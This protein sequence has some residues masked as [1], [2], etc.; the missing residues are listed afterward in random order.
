MKLTDAKLLERWEEADDEHARV[1][2]WKRETRS[3]NE[4][5]RLRNR[6]WEIRKKTNRYRQEAGRRVF[7]D[8][9]PDMRKY[10]S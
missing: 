5:R 6:L 3:A 9:W 7:E 4:K 2:Q 1:R 8:H 10:W